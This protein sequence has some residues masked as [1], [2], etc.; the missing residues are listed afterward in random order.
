M[1]EFDLESWWNVIVGQHDARSLAM[2]LPSLYASLCTANVTTQVTD[3]FVDL[4]SIANPNEQTS[5]RLG[6]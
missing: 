2:F 5:S 1:H 3:L 4:Q 6:N